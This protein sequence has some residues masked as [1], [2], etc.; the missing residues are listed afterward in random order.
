MPP[1]ALAE[2]FAAEASSIELPGGT[3]LAE[4]GGTVQ[5]LYQ[6]T[7]GR[8]AEVE[9]MAEGGGRLLAV[10]R[11]GELIGGAQ[12]LGDGRYRTTLTALR[13]SELQAIPADRAQ[14]LMRERPQF[15][16]EV[17]RA[18]LETLK[19]PQPAV[20]RKS[21]ILGFVAVSDSIVMRDLAEHLAAAMRAIGAEV[22][23]LGA[24]ADDCIALL[25]PRAGNGARLRPDGGRM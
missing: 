20:Q 14:A 16:A 2:V 13:D 22:A 23:V 10:H 6:L 11:P 1:N 18:A 24:E 19:P 25:A 8:L 21:S 3:P 4:A 12:L 7:A 15:L 9:P 5:A 17:A